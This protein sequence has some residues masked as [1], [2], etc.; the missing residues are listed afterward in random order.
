MQKENSFI[1]IVFILLFIVVLFY[2]LSIGASL[3]IPFV[4]AVLFSLA[5]I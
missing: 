1:T 2:I 5:I 3:I 4:I